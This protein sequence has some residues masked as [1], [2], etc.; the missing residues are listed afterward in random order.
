MLENIKNCR[1]HGT[2]TRASSLLLQFYPNKI[3]TTQDIKDDKKYRT[4]VHMVRAGNLVKM[5]DDWPPGY[6][7]TLLGRCCV[8]CDILGLRFLELCIITE[9]YIAGKCQIKHGCTVSYVLPA[10]C[11]YFDVI[12]GKKTIQ[13][14]GN[15]LCCKGMA[16]NTSFNVIR[17]K[18]DMIRKLR[19]YDATL[20]QLHKWIAGIPNQLDVMAFENPVLLEK[21]RS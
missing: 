21:I 14:T 17:L 5:N 13:N 12:Y 20:E 8:V 18:Q 6:S 1:R 10:M 16:D 4:I 15:M 19:K 3:L 2:G 11:D 7:L 9:A